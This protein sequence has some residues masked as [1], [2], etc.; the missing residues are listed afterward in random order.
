MSKSNDSETKDIAKS[1]KDFAIPCY[2]ELLVLVV[3]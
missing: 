3:Y 1:I 2:H